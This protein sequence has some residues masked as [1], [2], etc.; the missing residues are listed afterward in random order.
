MGFDIEFIVID[1]FVIAFYLFYCRFPADYFLYLRFFD[2]ITVNFYLIIADFFIEF[3][4]YF[5]I[6]FLL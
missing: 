6:I 3:F 5:V 2:F 4:A 1:F